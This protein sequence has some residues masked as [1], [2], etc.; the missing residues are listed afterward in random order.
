M[1]KGNDGW[2]LAGLEP[3]GVNHTWSERSYEEASVP[4]GP[5][6]PTSS[7]AG[8]ISRTASQAAETLAMIFAS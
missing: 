8:P 6:L 3:T 5:L 1:G 7:T 4:L 2:G